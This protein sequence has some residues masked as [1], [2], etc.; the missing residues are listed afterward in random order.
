MLYYVY[1]SSRYT[2]IL[3]TIFNM[4]ITIIMNHNHYDNDYHNDYDNHY[5]Y[6]YHNLY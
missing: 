6:N 2:I 4:I 5:H 1:I 3:L